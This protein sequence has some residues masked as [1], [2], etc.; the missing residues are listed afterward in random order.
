M[1]PRDARI[2][3]VVGAADDGLDSSRASIRARLRRSLEGDRRAVAVA[4]DSQRTARRSSGPPSRRAGRRPGA[5]GRA[6]RGRAPRPPRVRLA[7]SNRSLIGVMGRPRPPR[8]AADGGDIPSRGRAARGRRPIARAT[9]RPACSGVLGRRHLAAAHLDDH[10]ALD[11]ADPAGRAARPQA[12]DHR[13]GGVVRQ[14]QPL[15]QGR[16]QVLELQAE[17]GGQV[18]DVVLRRLARV[19][20]ATVTDSDFTVL[21]RITFTGTAVPGLVTTTISTRF[22]SFSTLRPLDRRRRRPDAGRPS[23]PDRRARPRAPPRPCGRAGPGASSP[24]AIACRDLAHIPA[25][26]TPLAANLL[27][28]LPHQVDRHCGSRCRC[29]AGR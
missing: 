24:R 5:G 3:G 20:S 22:L 21:S 29:C 23:P 2:A 8:L 17:A 16:R 13:A 25:R 28:Q 26:Q 4:P 10:V 14:L 18:L 12:A 9:R 19:S 27:Q 6:A 15:G 11:E 1:K 7:E